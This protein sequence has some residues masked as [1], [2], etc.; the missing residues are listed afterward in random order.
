MDWH[1][2]YTLKGDLEKIRAFLFETATKQKY[3]E[4]AG[5]GEIKKVDGF[6]QAV[7]IMKSLE[8]RLSD[9]ERSSRFLAPELHPKIKKIVDEN[10]IS[11]RATEIALEIEII[12]SRNFQSEIFSSLSSLAQFFGSTFGLKR[13]NSIFAGDGEIPLREMLVGLDRLL[14]ITNEIEKRAWNSEN[15]TKETFKP[16]N[17]DGEKILFHIENAIRSISQD[18]KLAKE[19]REKLEEYLLEAQAELAKSNPAWKKIVGALVIV[20]TILGGIAAAPEAL[21]NVNS[22]VKY[23]LGTAFDGIHSAPDH[24]ADLLPPTLET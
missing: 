22:A 7:T 16:A 10:P 6:D 3:F 4:V 18:P 14:P 12:D 19:E 11:N 13:R 23:L 15:S 21:N 2:I 24:G 9:L 17:I 5:L 20:S 8:P 1:D